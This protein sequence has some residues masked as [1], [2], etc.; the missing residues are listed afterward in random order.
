LV[1]GNPYFLSLISENPESGGIIARDITLKAAEV[2]DLGEVVPE[3]A[4]KA[5]RPP[6]VAV[7]DRGRKGS[8]DE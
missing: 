7:G 1:P 4:L 6:P 3:G 5:V 2:K 8:A